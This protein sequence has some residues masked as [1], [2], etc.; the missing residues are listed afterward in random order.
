MKFCSLVIAFL[1]TVNMQGQIAGA[2]LFGTNQV[3]TVKLNFN[4]PAFWDSL[5]AN[6]SSETNMV[7]ASLE[8]TDN[9][10][11]HSFSNINIRLKGNSSYGHPG[12]K[13]SFKIDLNDNVP[14]QNYDGLKKLNFNNCFKDPTFMREKVFFEL[15]NLL[16]APAPRV[17]YANVYMN[18]IFWGF[19]GLVEQVDDQFLDW[20]ILDDNGN[21]FKAGDNFGGGSNAADLMNYGTNPSAYYNRY[22]LKTNE[23]VNDWT[24]LVELIQFITTSSAQTFAGEFGNKINKTPYLR[25]LALDV[26]F[27]NLDSYLNSARNYYIYHNLTTS[28]WEW[29]KWDGNEAFGV[30]NGG[31]GTGN[32]EQLAIN[33]VAASR[34]LISNVFNNPILYEDY[35]NELCF[36]LKNYFTNAYLDPKIND[37][38][39]LISAHVYADNG[40]MYSNA[41]FDQNIE[42]NITG[43]GGPGG[44]TIYGLKSFI[45]NRNAYISN[46]LSCDGTL[47]EEV[48]NGHENLAYPNP[49]DNFIQL[50]Q[51]IESFSLMDATG[52]KL[53]SNSKPLTNAAIQ[54]G[55][56][57]SGV[58]IFESVSNHKVHRQ[59]IVKAFK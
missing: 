54:L 35:K 7:C 53:I 24:D 42:Q 20:A 14:G 47:V 18:N 1:F 38:K 16:G 51:E 2:N 30:Y 48:E 28:K 9:Q 31:P 36:I 40:K 23:T 44:G 3:I 56:L 59:I 57:P 41:Q 29:I 49:F 21:L 32:L 22:E 25:S 43:G 52:R 55:F 17:N 8:I 50:P 58:Y 26:L 13:K 12:N 4:Q 34:P 27:S 15:S 5:V 45:A 10:G 6:Y 11:M 33:Y 46:Q 39:A 19:Y 37:L